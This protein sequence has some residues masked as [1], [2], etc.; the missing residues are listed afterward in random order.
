M[1]HRQLTY[2]SVDDLGSPQHSILGRIIQIDAKLLERKAGFMKV[3]KM[4]I[5]LSIATELDSDGGRQDS[6]KEKQ[7]NLSNKF[8]N[9]PLALGRELLQEVHGS[10]LP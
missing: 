2:I 8:D 5:L 3:P 1:A 7:G 10:P 6:V 4:D 9:E